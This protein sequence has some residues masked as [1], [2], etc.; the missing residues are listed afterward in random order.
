MRRSRLVL[1]L[2]R[3][4]FCLCLFCVEGAEDQGG[5]DS[6]DYDAGDEVGAGHEAVEEVL[7]LLD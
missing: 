4:V 1:F 7:L 5:C 2:L 6:G 3:L